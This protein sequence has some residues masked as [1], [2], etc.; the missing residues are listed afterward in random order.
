MKIKVTK[1]DFNKSVVKRYTRRAFIAKFRK[2][3]PDADLEAYAK[4][5]GLVNEPAAENTTAPATTQPDPKQ[6]PKD[7]K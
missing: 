7:G 3:Y 2:V 1:I 4:Q 5:L 6:K